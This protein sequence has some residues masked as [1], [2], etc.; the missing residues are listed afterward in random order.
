[1]REFASVAEGEWRTIRWKGTRRKC[2]NCGM[3][4]EDEY[5]IVE[6]GGKRYLEIKGRILKEGKPCR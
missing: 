2:C 5:R 1:M 3:V 4:E 6:V